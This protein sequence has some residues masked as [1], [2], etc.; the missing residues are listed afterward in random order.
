MWESSKMFTQTN[1]KFQAEVKHVVYYA[2]DWNAET[3]EVKVST[4]FADL[5]K[6]MN[7]AVELY[8]SGMEYVTITSTTFINGE[9]LS[10]VTYDVIVNIENSAQRNERIAMEKALSEAIEELKLYKA[11]AK[12]FKAEETFNTFKIN[13]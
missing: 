10:E 5:D 1:P 12:K 3:D 8:N 13:Q 6:A 2:K 11:F 7:T 9:W 4:P